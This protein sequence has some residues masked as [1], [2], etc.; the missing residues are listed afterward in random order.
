MRD[1]ASES[2]NARLTDLENFVGNSY[3]DAVGEDYPYVLIAVKEMLAT[4]KPHAE[5]IE[6]VVIGLA[7]SINTIQDIEAKQNANKQQTLG[8]L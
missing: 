5:H 3:K 6:Q 7:S 2:I 1:G 4:L 8:A